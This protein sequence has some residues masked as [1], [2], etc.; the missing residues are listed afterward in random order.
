MTSTTL[1]A[2][3]VVRLTAAEAFELFGTPG[4]GSWLFDARCTSVTVGAPVSLRLP[5][6]HGDRKSVV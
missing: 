2:E 3:S 5:L 4:A 1:A 6:D